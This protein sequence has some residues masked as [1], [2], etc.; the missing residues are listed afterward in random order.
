MGAWS[1]RLKRYWAKGSSLRESFV[2]LFTFTDS[3]LASNLLYDAFFSR[4]K[5]LVQEPDG[6]IPET[7]R[8][9]LRE[10]LSEVRSDGELLEEQ[11]KLDLLVPRDEET[12]ASPILL[13]PREQQKHILLFLL[14]IAVAT[15]ADA[16]RRKGLASFAEKMHFPAADYAALEQE[17]T[18]A[19]TAQ[20][21]Q[22]L[23]SSAGIIVAVMV[24][25]IFILTATLLRSLV[26]GL[27]LAYLLL[28]LE[29][30]FERRFRKHSGIAYWLHSMVMLPLAPLQ[31]LSKVV[32]R[33]SADPKV[34][35]SAKNRRDRQVIRQAT[36][37]TF[38]LFLLF[39]CFLIFGAITLTGQYV[40]RLNPGTVAVAAENTGTAQKADASKPAEPQLNAPAADVPK[41]SAGSVEADG[42]SG[43]S[44][45]LQ[46]FLDQQM[47]HF[48]SKPAIQRALAQVGKALRDEE[49]QAE[50]LKVVLRRTGGIFSITAG[51][52]GQVGALTA[53]LLL[54]FFFAALFLQKMAEYC[55]NDKSA[56][57]IG[58]YI[59][60]SLFNG[61]W[62]PD[63]GP[64]ALRDGQ[65]I[66]G[67]VL[68]RLQVWVKGYLTLVCI[69]STVYCTV[70]FFLDVPYFP[71][72]GVLAG[73]GIL[74]PYIGPI[75]SCCITGIVTL[76]V[77]GSTGLQLC[78]IV[79]AY[80]IYNGII[81][82]F[83]LYPAVIG[84]ALGLTTLETIVFVLLGAIF[85]GIPGMLFA[86]PAASVIKYLIPQIYGTIGKSA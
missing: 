81:E 2:S 9:I 64:E 75:I 80:C 77:G 58:A 84:E 30:F 68:V 60:T 44:A 70:F 27:I 69:D 67:G 25:V 74:L 85:A 12:D 47:V 31:K 14:G 72:L 38:I 32:M 53:D 7:K 11:R 40:Q 42:L 82:Q 43:F 15:Q 54:T 16:E 39:A 46:E 17:V 49:M 73:C 45:Q 50:F 59:V 37:L 86:L 61:K 18:Q 79:I 10:M 63:P 8:K 71:I 62:L 65:R 20:K 23:R 48:S 4:V 35:E 22:V 3:E 28:P 56:K 21:N 55:R 13:L 1:S 36:G 19:R 52:L 66:I 83:L 5:W 24:L 34:P 57:T 29:K 41:A 51:V 78:G 6:S 33:R 26:F 76:A